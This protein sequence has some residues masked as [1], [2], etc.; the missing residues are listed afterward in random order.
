MNLIL[1]LT[2][3]CNL[4]CSYCYYKET[5]GARH[6]VMDDSTL[7]QAIRAGLERALAFGQNN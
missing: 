7:E 6:A 5:Q 3:Q 2:E 4:R 1:C